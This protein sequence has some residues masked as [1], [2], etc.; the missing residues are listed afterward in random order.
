MMQTPRTPSS[1]APPYSAVVEAAAKVVEGAA[2]QQRAHLRRDGVS[3]RVAQ[4]VAHKAA[5]AF[6]GFERHVAHKTVAD[7]HVGVAVEDVAAL[8]VA[9]EVDG[10]GLEQRQRLAGQV[11]ALGFFFADGEQTHARLRRS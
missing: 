5:D 7:D 2:R 8:H 6:A 11:V 4:H 3:E 9:D 1:G 10:Q